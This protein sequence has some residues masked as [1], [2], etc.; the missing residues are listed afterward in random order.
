MRI[1]EATKADLPM[2]RAA[3]ASAFREHPVY[4]WMVPRVEKRARMNEW[5][6]DRV[7]AYGLK[8]GHVFTDDQK[9]SASVSLPTDGT[10]ISFGRMVRMGVWRAPFR[11]GFGGFRRFLKFTSRMEEIHKKHVT[12][13][14][15]QQVSVG[16]LP[17]AHG[18]GIGSALLTAGTDLADAKG[19][20]CYTETVFERSVEWHER[21]GYE[22]VEEAAVPGAD[23]IWAMVR[24]PARPS[25]EES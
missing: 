4:D 6:Q 13:P 12:G 3:L 2:L 11:M 16:V 17:E 14:H 18:R 21:F 24:Q 23:R 15:F 9:M 25:G 8:Y 10:G 5:L 19:Q 20:I 22:V 7:A 1:V